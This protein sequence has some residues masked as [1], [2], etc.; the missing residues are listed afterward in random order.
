MV[1]FSSPFYME[2]TE[3][4]RAPRT[5]GHIGRGKVRASPGP[6]RDR[7]LALLY[8]LPPSCPCRHAF[9]YRKFWKVTPEITV[10]SMLEWTRMGEELCFSFYFCAT[11]I[12]REHFFTY[13]HNGNPQLFQNVKKRKNKKSTK[14]STK[15]STYVFILPF[16]QIK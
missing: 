4:Q 2:E 14:I 7:M 16:L 15:S 6:S 5:Q 3:V 1:W 11:G 8:F 13:V 12:Y 10:Y 9:I